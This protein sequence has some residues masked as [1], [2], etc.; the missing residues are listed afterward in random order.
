M[1]HSTVCILG[2]GIAG[3]T[4]AIGL[5]KLGVDFKVFESVKEL[6]NVGAGLIM[7][8][9]ALKALE[10]IEVSTKVKAAGKMM[11]GLSIK[12]QNG[13]LLQA[14]DINKID[15]SYNYLAIHRADLHQVLMDELKE[16][17]LVLG[18]RSKEI[19][20]S[21]NKYIITFENGLQH[22]CDYVI[23][24]EG[25]QSNLRQQIFP[26]V[27]MR[28]AGYS[29]WRGIT[30]YA[31]IDI[32]SE[33]WGKN[34]RFGIVPLSKDR[35]YWFAV[36]SCKE[37]DEVFASYTASQ[38]AEHFKGYHQ[39]V[40]ELIS[41]TDDTAIL[42]NSISDLKPSNQY[43]KEGICFIGDA[44]HATTPN[45]GQGACMAIEDAAMLTECLSKTGNFLE[46]FKLFEGK[47]IDRTHFIVNQS[48]KIGRLAQSRNPLLASFRNMAIKLI[49]SKIQQ[50]QLNKVFHFEI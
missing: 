15:S 17:Q 18:E 12:K 47:R 49:P 44:I 30:N 36:V 14:T 1:T 8:P 45:M 13:H 20:L 40:K 37:N 11:N 28:Y 24:A 38:I 43:A 6:K 34:G 19:N 23:V 22:S 41:T 4:T 3:L 31:G 48:W 5:N 32:A 33:T 25:I 29:C 7:A 27:Q 9:N 2:G 42:W 21:N 39:P 10:Y 46:A 26:D 35:V 16:G 50:K